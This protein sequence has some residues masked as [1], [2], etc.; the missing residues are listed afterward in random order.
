MNVNPDVDIMQW[1]VLQFNT[2]AANPFVIKCGATPSL[3]LVVKAQAKI[4]DKSGKEMV[5]V[6][7]PPSTLS[8]LSL[9]EIRQVLMRLPEAFC[10][11]ALAK[12]ADGTRARFARLYKTLAIRVPALKSSMPD[13]DVEPSRDLST[14]SMSFKRLG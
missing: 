13:A 12:T 11:L 1:S 2:G 4:Q 9:D 3:E 7:P 10:Q 6:V 8:G 14:A 5:S